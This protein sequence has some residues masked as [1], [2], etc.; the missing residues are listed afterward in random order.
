M[1]T[2]APESASCIVIESTQAVWLEDCKS[3][4]QSKLRRLGEGGTFY[5]GWDS[6]EDGG[7]HR[8]R[9]ANERTSQVLGRR[10]RRG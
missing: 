3:Q 2:K 10:S 4:W 8:Q 6:L 9:T 7:T 1:S 5:E